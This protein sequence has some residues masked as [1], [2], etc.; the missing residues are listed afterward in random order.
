MTT[1][2]LSSFNATAP[3]LFSYFVD[4]EYCPELDA[5]DYRADLLDDIDFD[6]EHEEQAEAVR[7]L[8]DLTWIRSIIAKA[9]RLRKDSDFDKQLDSALCH[10]RELALL[11]RA[12][13]VDMV[14]ELFD[15]EHGREPDVHEQQQLFNQFQ[16]A[17]AC[18]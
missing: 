2:T 10:V 13:F 14:C 9:P 18:R 11:H 17:R 6:E 1:A 5:F 3:E 12:E 8:D 15:E 4:S 7:A 16:L